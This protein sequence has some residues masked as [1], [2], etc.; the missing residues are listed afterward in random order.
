M[1]P[2]LPFSRP[3]PSRT[4]RRLMTRRPYVGWTAVSLVLALGLAGCQTPG[5]PNLPTARGFA[6]QPV[7]KDEA[8][9]RPYMEAMA[10]RYNA[11]PDDR[12][13]ALNYATALRRLTLHAQAVAVLQRLAVKH[14]QDLEILGAYGKALADDGRLQ[15]AQRVLAQAHTPDRPNWSVLSAQGSVADQLGDHAGAQAYYN[16]A[17]KIVPNQ[18]QVLSNLGLSYALERKMPQAEQTL[19]LAAMQP[20]ADARVRQNLAL[21]LG[22]EGKYADAEDILRRDLSPIDAAQN[23]VTIKQTIAQSDVWRPLAKPNRQYAA[24]RTNKYATDLDPP[25]PVQ[26]RGSTSV[27]G[28]DP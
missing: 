8:H 26:K 5:L 1:I 3:E 21:V 4:A 6:D 16:T 20:G 28:L 15:E 14:P 18:P 2:P 11:N 12:T 7:P 9:L 25:S 17:L 23:M 10:E 27:A 13:T 19:R 24:R 22:A